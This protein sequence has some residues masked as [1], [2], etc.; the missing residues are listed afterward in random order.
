MPSETTAPATETHEWT[1]PCGHHVDVL[2]GFRL[3]ELRTVHVA[4]CTALT[5][6]ASD[7]KE[8]AA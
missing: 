2:D 1:C 8:L 5:R 3:V 7:L 4:R 6:R